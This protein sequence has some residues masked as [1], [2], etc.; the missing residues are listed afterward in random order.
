MNTNPESVKRSTESPNRHTN[1]SE[2]IESMR[3]KADEIDI[4]KDYEKQLAD[5][6]F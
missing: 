6:G 4:L 5:Q 3:K 2:T 1:I